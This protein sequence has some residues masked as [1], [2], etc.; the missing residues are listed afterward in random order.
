MCDSVYHS[1][2]P[3]LNLTFYPVLAYDA[4]IGIRNFMRF[5]NRKKGIFS[6]KLGAAVAAFCAAAGGLY[7]LYSQETVDLGLLCVWYA[8]PMFDYVL[9]KNR[10]RWDYFLFFPVSLG[11]LLSGGYCLYLIYVVGEYPIY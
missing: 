8:Y 11:F 1:I 10:S 4:V 3:I 7:G 6:V 2:E 5:M 9:K